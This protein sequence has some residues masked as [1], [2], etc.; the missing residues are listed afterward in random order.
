MKRFFAF[1]TALIM[2]FTVNVCA[3]TE[4]SEKTEIEIV[5]TIT[6]NCGVN[7]YETS[8]GT[9]GAY[10]D[11]FKIAPLYYL[12]FEHY[13]DFDNTFVLAA[14]DSYILMKDY[15]PDN[16]YYVFNSK[17]ELIKTL[18]YSIDDVLAEEPHNLEIKYVSVLTA[19]GSNLIVYEY[20]G[21][22]DNIYGLSPSYIKRLYSE[23]VSDGYYSIWKYEDG[24]NGEFRAIE[25]ETFRR[26]ILNADGSFKEYILND[27]GSYKVFSWYSY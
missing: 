22:R 11:N 12:P 21:K 17:G 10:G 20:T 18:T 9:W 6:L 24:E 19:Y 4:S 7:L 5:R 15:N 16:T 13:Y 2:L 23:K 3:E 26:C 27:D 8:E 14:K 25:K 1:I